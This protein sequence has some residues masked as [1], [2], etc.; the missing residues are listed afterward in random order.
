MPG[1]D[2]L[3]EYSVSECSVCGAGREGVVGE[4][5]VTANK[6]SSWSSVS[7]LRTL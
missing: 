3:V 5:D 2:E 7:S 4:L 1:E 6:P